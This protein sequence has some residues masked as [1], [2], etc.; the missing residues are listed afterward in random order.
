[1]D[2]IDEARSC[3]T[4]WAA[5]VAAHAC[6][7]VGHRAVNRRYRYL[8][9]R[10]DA[11]LASVTQ[12][13]QFYQLICPVTGRHRPFLPR[14]MSVYGVGP[15]AG[16]IEFL[17]NVTGE[18]TRALAQLDA[19]ARLSI[20]GPLGRPFTLDPDARRL[21]FVARGVGLATMAPLVQRAAQAGI[22]L[23]VVMSARTPD[24]LMAAEFLRGARADVHAVFDSDGTS[25]LGNVDALLRDAIA[26]DRPDAVYTCGSQRLLALL[27]RVLADHPS[28]RGEVALEQRMACGMGV[29]LSCVRM[30]D[31]GEIR[32]FR[33]VCREGPVFA[34]RDVVAEVDFG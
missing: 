11:A 31:D 20:V 22:A 24:D 29:C 1:M 34:I 23:T 9:V 12:A 15:G 18:G 33:R 32:G 21:L 19:G 13:G 28:M 3:A 5:S 2:V 16:E 25:A 17:Y 4:T 8:R 27:Q 30:F 14:P 6:D 10:A 26:R 7:V